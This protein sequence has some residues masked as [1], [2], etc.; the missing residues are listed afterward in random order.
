LENSL[1]AITGN[2]DNSLHIEGT[3]KVKIFEF[4]S[5]LNQNSAYPKRVVHLHGKYDARESIILCGQEY[6]EKYGFPVKL[7][8]GTLFDK[9]KKGKLAS[10]EFQKLLMNYGYEWP[11]RRKLLWSILATRRVVFFGF[12][13]SDPYFQKMFDYVS[14][15]INPF[16][17]DTH[18]L[19]L[20]ITRKDKISSFQFAQQLKSQYGIETVFFTDD[21][22]F[23]GLENFILEIGNE[24]LEKR[25][26][27]KEQVNTQLGPN[28]I[29]ENLNEKL[30]LL[31]KK[32]IFDENK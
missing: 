16:G 11:L 15:D 8:D 5:S 31:N 2:P 21:E 26:E 30:L 4:L 14:S 24:L 23:K 10:E 7:P 25:S 18:F 19:I 20:R 1:L 13:M 27:E 6:L 3:T 22:S 29:N 12:S 32:Q 28:S 9:I 17:S